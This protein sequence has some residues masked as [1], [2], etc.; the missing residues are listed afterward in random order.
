MWNGEALPNLPSFNDASQIALWIGFADG[1][2]GA[3]LL[4]VP[5]PGSALL[6]LTGLAAQAALRQP[7]RSR[8]AG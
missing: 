2:E 8:T 1:T 7:L 3:F 4:T 5:E 6:L